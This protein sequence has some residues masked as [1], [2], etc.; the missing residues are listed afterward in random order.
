VPVIEARGMGGC[1]FQ[2][3]RRRVGGVLASPPEK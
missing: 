2:A 1:V 3:D